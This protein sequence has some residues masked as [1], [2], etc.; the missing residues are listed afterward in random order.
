MPRVKLEDAPVK[1]AY[2]FFLH[3]PIKS[4]LSLGDVH[5][6]RIQN[7]YDVIEKSKMKSKSRSSL[8]TNLPY[9]LRRQETIMK[10]RLSHEKESQDCSL[11][12]PFRKIID[13][14]V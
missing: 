14:K 9:L 6:C 13:F 4:L 11:E 5:C 8:D 7:T 3:L 2:V 12:I 10:A 1:N